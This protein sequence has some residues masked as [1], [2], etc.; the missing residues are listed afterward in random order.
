MHYLTYVTVGAIIHEYYMT[1]FE[2][3]TNPSQFIPAF[4]NATS[5]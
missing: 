5:A 3:K 1:Q 4:T 2:A